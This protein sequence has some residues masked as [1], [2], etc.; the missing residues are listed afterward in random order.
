MPREP[1][2]PQVVL[3]F[4]VVLGC[5]VGDDVVREVVEERWRREVQKMEVGR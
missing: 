3:M 4:S 1:E 5:L 2:E